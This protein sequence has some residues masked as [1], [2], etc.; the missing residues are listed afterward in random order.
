MPNYGNNGPAPIVLSRSGHLSRV[1]YPDIHLAGGLVRLLQRTFES[2]DPETRVT[3][4]VE[5]VA[6]MPDFARVELQ[7][8][9]SQVY[10][11]G[12]QR[13]FLADF[14]SRGVCLAHC[15]FMEPEVLARAILSWTRERVMTKELASRY[16][17]LAVDP[18]AQGFEEGRE[19][20]ERWRSY[21]DRPPA[22]ELGA[23]IRAAAVRPELRMLFPF[24]SMHFL[25]FSRCTGYPYT[26][27]C[28]VIAPAGNGRY[29]V[30]LPNGTTSSRLV[31]EDA[32]R[33]A[34]ANLP[35]GC[36]PALP[37]TA[38]QFKTESGR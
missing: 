10:L 2:L 33:F 31:A 12:E 27:D 28:P 14:W 6:G 34:T 21:L 3:G 26:A 18:Q 23:V 19:V 36:G 24:T 5:E 35:A 9:F 17:A 15:A 11:A 22:P 32:V 13:L 29:S 38:H 7:E 37:G 8:R 1:L 25:C 4:M 20:H 16:P 30:M